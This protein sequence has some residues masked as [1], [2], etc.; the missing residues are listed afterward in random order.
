MFQTKENPVKLYFFPLMSFQNV[1]ISSPVGSFYFYISAS[2]FV[3]HIFWVDGK[4]FH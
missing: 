3:I 4:I 2:K 1:S